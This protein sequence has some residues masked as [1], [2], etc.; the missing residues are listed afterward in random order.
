MIDEMIRK[1][2]HERNVSGVVIETDYDGVTLGAIQTPVG[3]IMIDAPI[4]MKTPRSGVRAAAVPE[5]ELIG[6]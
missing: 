5:Q 1:G 6:C 3:V 2:L 4:N